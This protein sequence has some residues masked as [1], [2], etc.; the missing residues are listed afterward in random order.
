MTCGRARVG[1]VGGV[2]R[3]VASRAEALHLLV[4]L[5]LLSFPAAVHTEI[6]FKASDLCSTRIWRSLFSQ[7]RPA[8]PLCSVSAE[9]AARGGLHPLEAS[10][11]PFFG[12]DA[13]AGFALP[14]YHA[15]TYYAS[16]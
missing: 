9:V 13:H 14:V 3:C 2:A 6:R 8:F 4:H 16:P 12:S 11:I 10:R 7:I 5:H 1:S 15:A